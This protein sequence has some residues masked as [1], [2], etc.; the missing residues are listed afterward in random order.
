MQTQRPD[1]SMTIK[2]FHNVVDLW[3]H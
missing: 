1:L 2:L 3:I